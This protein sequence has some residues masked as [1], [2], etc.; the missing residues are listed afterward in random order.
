M[1]TCKGCCVLILLLPALCNRVV[2]YIA[3]LAQ[4]TYSHGTAYTVYAIPP[5]KKNKKEVDESEDQ[6]AEIQLKES[7]YLQ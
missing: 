1:Y 6:R 7:G 2:A 3:W 5:I 4:S